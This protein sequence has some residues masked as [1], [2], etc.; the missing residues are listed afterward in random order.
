VKL[1][2]REEIKART[3][4]GDEE[5]LALVAAGRVSASP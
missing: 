1:L 5:L 4:P 2:R 3:R